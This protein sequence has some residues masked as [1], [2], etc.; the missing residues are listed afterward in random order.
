MWLQLF[1][2]TKKFTKS[3]S[4]RFSVEANW[5]VADLLI[6][7]AGKKIPDSILTLLCLSEGWVGDTELECII[8]KCIM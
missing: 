3:D 8:I 5:I 7:N 4:S 2:K 1:D 6:V